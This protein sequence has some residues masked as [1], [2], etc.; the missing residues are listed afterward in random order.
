[1]CWDWQA[2]G[3]VLVIEVTWPENMDTG[4]IPGDSFFNVKVDGNWTESWDADWDDA[5][6]LALEFP[7]TG[8]PVNHVRLRY[9][10]Y[11]PLLQSD[12]GEDVPPF[13]TLVPEGCEEE[14]I[15]IRA[16][17]AARHAIPP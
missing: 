1:M 10:P 7:D 2:I 9:G 12:L 14:K 6:T 16:R 15:G 5:V 17:Y 13:N 11:S 8:V 4:Q 3:S